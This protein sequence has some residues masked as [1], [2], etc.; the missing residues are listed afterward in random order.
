MYDPEC[1]METVEDLTE[2]RIE[3]LVTKLN[4]GGPGSG[5]VGHVTAKQPSALHP[6]MDAAPQTPGSKLKAHLQALEHG[7]VMPGMMTESGKPVVNTME[8]ARAHG[9]DV[10]DHVDA[11][12]AHYELAQK[13]NAILE[14]LKTA[15]GKRDISTSDFAQSNDHGHAAM[16][17]RLYSEMDGF[18]FADEPRTIHV[19]SKGYL[20]LAKVD[21]GIYSGAFTKTNDGMEDHARVRI[22]RQTIPE[23]VQ[24]MVAQE[25]IPNPVLVAPTDTVTEMAQGGPAPEQYAALNSALTAPAPIA[26]QAPPSIAPI[27]D[28]MEQRLRM[29]ELISKLVG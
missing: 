12:N 27:I 4:K 20:V 15:G 1:Q 9:Y 6:H 8:A 21:D 19:G 11:M 26:I 7:G 22:E 13:T 23:L 24:F 28:P 5:V 14:K 25:W 17:E 2:D 3:A 18:D 10:Q 16:M 29:L